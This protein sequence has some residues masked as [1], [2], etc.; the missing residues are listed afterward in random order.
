MENPQA[1]PHQTSRPIRLTPGFR[2][3]HPRLPPSSPR[4]HHPTPARRGPA[5]S[6]RRHPPY[7][8]P[9]R[10]AP[11][12][13]PGR[14]LIP[15]ALLTLP[16][17]TD[18][19]QPPPR[20]TAPHRAPTQKARTPGD[21]PGACESGRYS[22]SVGGPARPRRR[23]GP[24]LVQARTLRMCSASF[25][26]SRFRAATLNAWSARAASLGESMF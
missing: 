19:A 23:R 1:R 15:P 14:I 5:R 4:P 16:P 21:H 18:A 17:S 20:P 10:A 12:Q 6:R 11:P 26:G 3:P 22:T 2:L 25:F 24:G 9:S 7:H 8:S 13:A